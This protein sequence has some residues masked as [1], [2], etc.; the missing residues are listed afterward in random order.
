V[1]GRNRPVLDF[2]YATDTFVNRPLAKHYG[3][4]AAFGSRAGTDEWVHV[5]DAGRY[6]RGGL[7]PMAVFLTKNAPGLRTS[8]VKRGYWVVR[9]L[10]G[11]RIPPPPPAVPELPK[12]EARLGELTLPQ[13]LARHRADKSCAGCHNRFDSIGLAFEGFGPVG[14]RRSKD[15]GGRPVEARAPFPDGSDRAGVD[16]L[17]DYLRAKREADF[18]DNLCKK[19]LSYAL[20][21]SLQLSD[22]KLLDQM[23]ARLAADGYAFGSLAET[24]VTSPQFLQK[25]GREAER[26]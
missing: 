18:I 12:D 13:V 10:L 5:A 1:A 26:E 15:L 21:R 6:G 14:E 17:R 7:L 20:G 9:S 22:Q 2:L 25:R 24:I 11:E 16:G 3:M 8:P 23:K 19:L 4:E